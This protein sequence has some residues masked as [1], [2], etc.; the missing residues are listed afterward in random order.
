MARIILRPVAPQPQ[1]GLQIN[2]GLVGYWPLQ[3]STI[4][5]GL[6]L[7]LS[8][9]GNHGT[10]VGSPPLV[11]GIG[12][13]AL[14]FN[15]ISQYVSIPDAAS[16]R[17]ASMSICAWFQVS[18]S[19]SFAPIISRALNG[20]PW[21]NPY[22]SFLIRVDGT[23]SIEFDVGNGS[24]FS[25]NSTAVSL[26]IN[27]PYFVCMT[28]DGANNVDFINGL[29]VSSQTNI[30]GSIGYTSGFATLI[31]ADVGIG[32]PPGPSEFF[33]G[34][35]SGV[36]IYNRALSVAEVYQLW[37]SGSPTL[38]LARS[39]RV[40]LPGVTTFTGEYNA[41]IIRPRMNSWR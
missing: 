21:T 18:A 3:A 11:P 25:G 14:S 2:K 12:G 23:S 41:P 22:L 28:Y 29:Q 7:D 36:R 1:R 34:L 4:K 40:L 30:T 32:S 37:A 16:L 35:I 19:V 8:G 10:I 15:G 33:N 6:A 38:G 31:G 13:Q 27:K 24:A 20:P 26:S 17:P 39:R 5:G 9:D